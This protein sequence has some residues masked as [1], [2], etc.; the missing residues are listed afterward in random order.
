MR[1][2]LLLLLLLPR[3]C[4]YIS[5]VCVA[6]PLLQ[7]VPVAMGLEGQ[8]VMALLGGMQGAAMMLPGAQFGLPAQPEVPALGGTDAD[9]NAAAMV[10]LSFWGLAL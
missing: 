2:A 7:Y 6:P 4:V 5:V 9:A 3:L 8:N 10:G 1:R